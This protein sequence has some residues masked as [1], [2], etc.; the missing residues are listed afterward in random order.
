MCICV[1]IFILNGYIYICLTL[2]MRANF[3]AGGES[4]EKPEAEVPIG[5]QADNTA[6]A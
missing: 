2:L 5:Q 6:V 1:F 4:V 3:T